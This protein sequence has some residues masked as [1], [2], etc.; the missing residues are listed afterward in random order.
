MDG[1]QDEW[2]QGRFMSSPQC[3]VARKSRPSKDCAAVAPR[4]AMISDSRAAISESLG[5]LG[6]RRLPRGSHLKCLTALVM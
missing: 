5:F 1:G 3:G 6:M 2:G 4:Q